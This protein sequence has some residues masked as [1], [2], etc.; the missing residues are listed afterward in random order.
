[1]RPS[2]IMMM[3]ASLSGGM[4]A[5]AWP[6]SANSVVPSRS[7][8]PP[9]AGV[10]I[11]RTSRSFSEPSF[12]SSFSRIAS[13]IGQRQQKQRKACGPQ[14]GATGTPDKQQDDQQQSGQRQKRQ[15]R[16]EQQRSKIDVPVHLLCHP[17]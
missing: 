1:M 14:G 9:V 11:Q 10:L 4:S 2:V 13:V 6:R 12:A 7:D 16:R 5:S 17:D 15:D 3:P 8:A